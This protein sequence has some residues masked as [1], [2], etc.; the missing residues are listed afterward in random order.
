M[1]RLVIAMALLL[2]TPA[3]AQKPSDDCAVQRK[4]NPKAACS[5]EI[6][7]SEVEGGKVGPVG[8]RLSGRREAGR[9]EL[10]RYRVDW[11]DKMISSTR[12]L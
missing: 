4:K 1:K 9:G 10:I 2:S 6:E 12:R 5:L 8:D 7:G 11:N 3:L